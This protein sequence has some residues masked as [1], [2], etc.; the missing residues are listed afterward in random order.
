MKLKNPKNPVR[1]IRE[2]SGTTGSALRS[3]R[4]V[5]DAVKLDRVARASHAYDRLAAI[6]IQVG[7]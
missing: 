4:R 5:S 3:R 6:G 1:R 2:E 7:R